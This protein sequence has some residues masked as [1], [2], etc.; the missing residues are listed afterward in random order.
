M[1]HNQEP[2]VVIT[3]RVIHVLL[4]SRALTHGDQLLTAAS[5]MV[6]DDIRAFHIAVLS[7]P[8][9]SLQS[10]QVVGM[11]HLGGRG[12]RRAGQRDAH[13]GAGDC[14][15]LGNA[16]EIWSRKT[17]RCRGRHPSAC[18]PTLCLS[19][20][21]LCD[22]MQEANIACRRHAGPSRFHGSG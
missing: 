11:R 18:T 3:Y 1:P 21:R 10:W 8:Q 12:Y 19:S 17:A 14:S 15:G 13:A 6:E 4:S 7:V 9:K 2:F 22:F 5:R 16:L 20:L